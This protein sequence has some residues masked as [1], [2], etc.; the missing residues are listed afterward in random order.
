MTILFVMQGMRSGGA[1]RVMS[2]LC[3]NLSQRREKVILAITETMDDF[4]YKVSSSVEIVDITARA[5]NVKKARIKQIR[6]LRKLYKERKP[7]VVV[8]FITRINI[9]AIIAGLGIKIPIIISERNNPMVDPA[10]KS[11]RKLRDIVYPFANGY[12]FQTEFAKECFSERIQKE[13][14]VIFNPVSDTVVEVDAASRKK[15]IIAVGRLEPQKNYSMMLQSL[16]KVLPKYPDYYVD[17]FGIGGLAKQLQKE[18]DTLGMQERIYLRG[19]TANVIQELADSEVYLMTSNFEGMPNALMEAMCVGCACISTDAPAYGA[20]ELIK[21]GENGF[22]VPV[23]DE[24]ALTKKLDILL[25]SPEMIQNFGQIAKKV[26][27]NFKTETIVDQW[28]AY[29]ERVRGQ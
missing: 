20:R 8:S 24:S 2:L 9:C 4:A 11:T 3:N 12:V 26:Y 29:I 1:E 5:G 16:A 27:A 15:R 21:D 7:D 23:N 10:S 19:F 28:L 18:I 22:L 13:S 14:E 25:S 6:N 17:I